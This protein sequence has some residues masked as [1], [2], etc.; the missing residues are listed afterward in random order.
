MEQA[1]KRVK[2][3]VMSKEQMMDGLERDGYVIL[4]DA[5]QEDECDHLYSGF[6][7]YMEKMNPELDRHNRATWTKDSLPLNTKGLIQHYNIGFQ[8]FTVDAHMLLK[9]VFEELYGTKK[10]WTSFDGVSFTQRGVRPA[11]K[12]VDD[13]KKK[14]W[15]RN[16][17]HIDQT[18]PGF[19]SVQGGLAVTTQKEDEHV[20]V[21]IPGSHLYHEELLDLWNQDAKT[22]YEAKMLDYKL[23]LEQWDGQ[24]KKPVMPK[25]DKPEQHW[26]IMN[27]AQLALLKSRGLEMKRIPLKR[28]SFVLWDSRTVHSSAG[29]CQ[30]APK[31]ATRL[32]IFV[33]MRPAPTDISVVKKDMELRTKAYTEGRVSKHSAD[34]IRLFGKQPRAYS[35]KDVITHEKMEVPK[36]IKMTVEEECVYGLRMYS[37]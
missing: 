27:P 17:V 16:A 25:L 23:A 29:Y 20:F 18:T 2:Q 28:G 31:E 15:D 35:V 3:G 12:D 32:Q 22:R 30:S 24:D 5:L 37:E 8:R 34:Q 1:Q 36:S 11:Y 10:L 6:W 4:E 26:Q 9:P 7:D 21:C 19:I 33:C 14:C 13:W